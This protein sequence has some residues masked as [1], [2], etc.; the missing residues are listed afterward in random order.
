METGGLDR[1]AELGLGV[2]HLGIRRHD[3]DP[4]GRQQ[5]A[6]GHQARRQDH[7]RAASPSTGPGPRGMYALPP[8][9]TDQERVSAR[10]RPPASSTRNRGR[11]PEPLRCAAHARD[12]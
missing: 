10:A 11:Q 4:L 7:R 9:T 8:P 2:G 3:V 1:G 5:L 12:W 6:D